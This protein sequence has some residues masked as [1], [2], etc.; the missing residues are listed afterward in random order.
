MNLDENSVPKYSILPLPF[1][2]NNSIPEHEVNWEEEDD[3]L[4]RTLCERKCPIEVIASVFDKDITLV[5]EHISNVGVEY[6]L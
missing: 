6:E 2:E 1:N 3:A 5:Q 4:L